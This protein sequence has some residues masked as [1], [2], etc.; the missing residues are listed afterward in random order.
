[1]R[2]LEAT[3]HRPNEP[4]FGGPARFEIVAPVPVGLDAE[5]YLVAL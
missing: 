3:R 2:L 4:G 1:M 5:G